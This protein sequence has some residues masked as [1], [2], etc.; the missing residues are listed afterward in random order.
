ML[1]TMTETITARGFVDPAG[2]VV[3]GAEAL[4]V[5]VLTALESSSVVHV[6]LQGLRGVPSSFFNVLLL[7]VAGR[8]GVGALGK[9][10]VFRFDND[11]Q[12]RIYGR[13]LEAVRAQYATA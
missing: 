2:T 6:D 12:L 5:G 7:A 9:R 1:V 10:L 3:A 8:F 13:S 11:A 4:A